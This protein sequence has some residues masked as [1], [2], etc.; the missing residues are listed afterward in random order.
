MQNIEQPEATPKAKTW[1]AE[2]MQIILRYARCF[3]CLRERIRTRIDT[4]HS[5]SNKIK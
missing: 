5:T 4:K 2:D 3:I 1:D